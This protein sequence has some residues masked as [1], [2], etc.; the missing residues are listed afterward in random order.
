MAWVRDPL[1]LLQSGWD[2]YGDIWAFQ[3]QAG[4]TFVFIN[5]TALVEQVFTA[6]P[7]V[8]HG[9]DAYAQLATALLG[10]SSLLTLDEG[11]HEQVRRLLRPPFGAEHIEHF[12][13]HVTRACEDSLATWP[14]GTPVA[15][16]GR[17]QEITLQAIM[18][19]VF[20]V[21]G[22]MEERLRARVSE[23]VAYGSNSRRMAMVQLWRL[24]DR[25]PRSFARLV[26][27]VNADVYEVIAS[28]R[29]D[30]DLAARGDVLATLLRAT[31]DD[32][33][34]MSDVEVRDQ[35]VTLLLQGHQSTGTALAW[36]LERL[37]RHPAV[38]DR[39][40]SELEDGSEEYLDAVVR[41]LLR[42]RPPLPMALRMTRQ[43]Y[44][45]GGYEVGPGVSLAP[46]SLIVQRRP[47]IYPEPLQFRPE[48]FLGK[49]ESPYTWFPFGGAPRSC[50]GRSLATMEIKTVLRTLVLGARFEPSSEPDEGFT[51]RG[52]MFSP[53][54]GGRVLLRERAARSRA[55]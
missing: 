25:L 41:E 46:C 23:I 38:L 15:T 27:A 2:R 52:V 4:I 5:D 21:S 10:G 48:R 37:T 45:I 1:A 50:I 20:G 29:R 3:M 13:E 31:Y 42:L 14:L 47:D 54:Q 33:T 17:M 43:P 55:L 40:R 35:L 26:S 12:R 8:L 28:A 49:P 6:D 36:A 22:A 18:A 51:R 32:G 39:L 9:G 34:P 11:E 19:A 16:L 44:E 53:K 30:P 7:T 24:R